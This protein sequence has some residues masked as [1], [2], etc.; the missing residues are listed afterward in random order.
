MCVLHVYII[1]HNQSYYA[2]LDCSRLQV[3]LLLLIILLGGYHQYC[4]GCHQKTREG[5]PLVMTSFHF[6][7]K[8]VNWPREMICSLEMFLVMVV[9][10]VTEAVATAIVMWMAMGVLP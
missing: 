2:L 1:H 4:E 9:A 10:V 5:V 7:Q 6:L 3:S 8:S